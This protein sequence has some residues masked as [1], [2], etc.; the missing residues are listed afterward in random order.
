VRTRRGKMVTTFT[1]CGLHARARAAADTRNE[2]V[3]VNIA[4][5][6][7][8]ICKLAFDSATKW[9]GRTAGSFVLFFSFFSFLLFRF[10]FFFFQRDP[11]SLFLSLFLF[12]SLSSLSLF[13]SLLHS[14]SVVLPSPPPTNSTESAPESDQRGN[15]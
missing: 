13:Q 11:P 14:Q 15:N 3:G 4:V 5:V 2:N 7:G 10:L 6:A 9:R 12:L 1:K 8:S